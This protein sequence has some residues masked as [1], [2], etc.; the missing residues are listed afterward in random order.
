MKRFNI[1]ILSLLAVFSFASCEKVIDI[2]LD[3]AE[4]RLVV[5]GRISDESGPYTVKLSQTINYDQPNNFPNISGATVTVK[6]D[7]GADETLIETAPGEYSTNSIQGT[8]GRTY[9]LAINYEGKDYNAAVKMAAPINID[10]VNIEAIIL[11]GGDEAPLLT[12]YFQDPAG[13]RNYYYLNY[14]INGEDSGDFS[15]LSD[16][17]RDGDEIV[18]GTISEDYA[19]VDVGD[20]ITVQLQCID[21]SMYNYYLTLEALSDGGGS[22]IGS[23][24]P[25]NPTSNITGGA[26]GYFKVYAQMEMDYI[27][28]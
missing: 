6:D 12:T 2:K 10:S 5:T 9:S 11:P 23:T 20:T 18:V 17:L 14:L 4:P 21:A 3:N 19:T 16:E 24:T 25:D 26:L 22:G 15:F 13:V 8:P 28:Q 27:I 1:L 7:N